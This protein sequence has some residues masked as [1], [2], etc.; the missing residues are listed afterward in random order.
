VA[1][2]RPRRGPRLRGAALPRLKISPAFERFFADG[3]PGDRR[4][5][6]VVYRVPE[7]R[8]PWAGM[9]TE[10]RGKRVP[11]K[12]DYLKQLAREQ[13]PVEQKLMD[14][15]RRQG[16]RAL[17]RRGRKKA[18]L[19]EDVGGSALPVVSVEL[20]RGML[21]ALAA[22]PDVVAILPNQRI[23]LIRPKE[24]DY[25]ALSARESKDGLTWGLKDLRVPEL[26]KRTRGKGIKVAVLDTGVYADHPALRGRVKGFVVVDPLGRRIASSPVFDCGSH[27]THVCGTIAGGTAGGVAIGVAPQAS[28]YVAAV[29]IGEPTLQTLLEGIGWAIE[30]GVDV[31]NLSLGFTYYEPM[32]AEVFRLLLS[33]YGIVPVVAVGN[34]NH[35]NTSSPGNAFNA[36]SVGAVE[37]AGGGRREVPFFSSGASLVFPGSAEGQRIVTKPDVVAPGVQVFSCI[38]PEKK[39][40]AVYEYSYMDGTSM[41][42]PHVAGAVALLMAARPSA[43]PEE[44]MA[45]LRATA[46][47]PTPGKD[48]RPDN[49]W[50]YGAIRPLE[51]LKAL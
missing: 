17:P 49:R 20:T 30:Q 32:F 1:R 26:W 10:A 23:E 35:G 4:E 41:A 40:D 6:L 44:I 47:H 19:V 21:P 15:Y 16:V 24:V 9:A 25:A 42:T 50:G 48:L 27:G 46:R 28:L 38:P 33:R 29:L 39:A 22:N 18:L 45:A 34:E 37:K 12:H 11:H 5:A 13:R 8:A 43:P 2:R 31:V 36:F 51:A 3:R 14:S 7:R